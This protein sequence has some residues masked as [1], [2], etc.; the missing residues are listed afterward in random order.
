M[1][2]RRRPRR[3]RHWFWR[4]RSPARRGALGAADSLALA[5]WLAEHGHGEGAL[6]VAR[7]HLRDHPRGPGAAEAQLL[8]GEIL[9]ARGEWASA[10]QYLRAVLDADPHGCVGAQARGALARLEAAQQPR[11]GHLHTRR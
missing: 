9:L 2:S 8:A 5:G 6:V 11:I 7:N 1:R 4:G 10:Y 3:R